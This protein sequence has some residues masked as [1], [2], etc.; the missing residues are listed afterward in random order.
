MLKDEILALLRDRGDYVSGQETS[1]RLGVTRAAV[2]KAVEALRREG[3]T[4][5]S[6]THR[7]Y[8]LESSP[9]RLS[10]GEVL[11]YLGKHPWANRVQILDTVESTNN[12]CKALAAQGAPSGTVVAAD[13]QTGGRGRMGR[14]FFS[15]PGKGVY[16]SV[17]L[18]PEAGPGE[19][20]HLTC[21][22][23]AAMCDGVERACGLRPEIKWTNDLILGG[24]KL[25][26]ILTELSIE[27][28][29]GHV[30][31][32]V[33]GIGVNCC[34]K[35]GEFPP[36]VADKAGSLEMAL[37]AAVDRNRLTA[38]MIRA[39]EELSRT[40][41]SEKE[42]WMEKY[43]RDCITI[44]KEVEVLR[45]DSIEK[46]LA[47]DVDKDGGLIVRYEDGRE[48][49]VASGEVSVRGLYGYV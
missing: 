4:I 2:W 19:L 33:L 35:P 48:E 18:R 30:Q 5:S 11:A 47:L 31:Y 42:K 38:E 41:I 22:F 3:Y 14:A 24:R 8:R 37:G 12:L 9:N 20:L 26:G 32:A 29:S 15:P 39:A 45:F 43:R 49:I 40:L 36:E 25:A 13:Q 17:I 21:A 23:A 1:S 6:V 34:Q 7:G 27:A 16:L 10:Q 46:G 28:E 44:G